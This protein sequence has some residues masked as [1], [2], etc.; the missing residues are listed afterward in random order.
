MNHSLSSQVGVHVDIKED[1]WACWPDWFPFLA[2]RKAPVLH[3][4]KE[5][6]LE[7]RE[8]KVGKHSTTCY[9]RAGKL[10][11]KKRTFVLWGLCADHIQTQGNL[12]LFGLCLKCWTRKGVS[13]RQDGIWG[14]CN[15]PLI[16][17]PPSKVVRWD[18]ESTN[19]HCQQTSSK[20]PRPSGWFPHNILETITKA[21]TANY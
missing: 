19:T 21:K 17:F 20:L 15:K 1:G 16:P 14:L 9:Q 18:E 4:S 7:P 2:C 11:G 3:S 8:V 6:R 12:D 10:R 5:W 13:K